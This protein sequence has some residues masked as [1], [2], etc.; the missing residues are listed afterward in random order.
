MSDGL[1][2][3]EEVYAVVGCA[4]TVYNE[5]KAGYLEAVY[6]EAMEIV[7][8]KEG[9]EFES[10]KPVVIYFQGEPLKKSYYA[11]LIADGKVLI[12]LKAKKRLERE[13]EAQLLNY[14]RGTQMK[15]GLLINFGNTRKLEWRRYLLTDTYNLIQEEQNE[16]NEEDLF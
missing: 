12:E 4:M 8:R 9:I 14:L 6:Q 1:L 16:S 3:K 10:Q 13:D 5:L 7:M 11:D 15:V 2:F